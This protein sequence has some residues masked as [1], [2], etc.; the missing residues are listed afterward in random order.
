MTKMI[1]PLAAFMSGHIQG[2][3]RWPMPLAETSFDVTIEAGLAVVETK[4]LFRNVEKHAIEAALTF[5]VPIHATFFHLEAEIEGRKLIACA[6]GKTEARK[7]YEGAIERGKATALHEE[8]LPGIHLLSV[9]NIKPGAEISVTSRWVMPLLFDGTFGHLR[10][11]LTVGEVYGCSGL[12]DADELISGGKVQKARLTVHADINSV[13][14]GRGTQARPLETGIAGS[15]DV[16][17]DVPIDLSVPAWSPRPLQGSMK[18]GIRAALQLTPAASKEDALSVAILVDKSGSMAGRCSSSLSLTTHEATRTA[19]GEIADR[20]RDQDVIDLW[21]FDIR[22]SLVGTACTGGDGKTTT[23]RLKGM[24]RN[25]SEP[26]GGTRIDSAIIAA[27]QHSE[28]RDVLILTDGKSHALD[29]DQLAKLGRRISA[30]FIGEDSLEAR[31]GSLVVETGG[32]MFIA[33]GEDIGKQVLAALSALRGV[34]D[35]RPSFDWPADHLNFVHNNLAVDA[36]FEHEPAGSD[37]IQLIN[38]CAVAAAITGLALPLIPSKAADVLAVQEGILTRRTSLILIDE[39]GDSQKGLP[40]FRKVRL[41]RPGTAVS[42]TARSA[43]YSPKFY[44]ISHA[45]IDRTSLFASRMSSQSSTDTLAPIKSRIIDRVGRLLGRSAASELREILGIDVMLLIKEPA[46]DWAG[47][48]AEL[49]N[50]NASSLPPSIQYMAQR[51]AEKR[52]IHNLAKL[53]AVDP[54]IAVLGLAALAASK[55]DR[56]AKRLIQHLLGDWENLLPP[57]MV[58]L[59]QDTL[60]LSPTG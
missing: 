19:L 53:L 3:D 51:I 20:L 26:A 33:S 47:H 36:Q 5:P 32:H 24:A 27:T 55:S 35:Q 23:A 17:M 6:K 60:E 49:A 42:R 1:D 25:L 34:C 7:D 45:S 13:M 29:V 41:A 46:L 59:I 31:L 15:T 39:A 11:P 30:I 48:A 21:E 54:Y 8:L 43:H 44:D 16:P 10:I 52:P 18:N 12:S 57:R 9:A 50:R 22:P 14:L 37:Q 2:Q 4:R 58:K 40:A 56:H 28:V 38:P